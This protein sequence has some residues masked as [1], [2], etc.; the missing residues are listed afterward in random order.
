MQIVEQQ[1]RGTILTTLYR[2]SEDT[3]ITARQDGAPEGPDVTIIKAGESYVRFQQG[4]G[5][6]HSSLKKAF[7]A[8]LD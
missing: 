4:M 7:L 8:S 5:H 6:L 2:V 3:Y 1:L